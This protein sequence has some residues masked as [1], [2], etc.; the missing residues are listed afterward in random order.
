MVPHIAYKF[1][2]AYSKEDK[3][4]MSI[5]YVNNKAATIYRHGTVSDIESIIMDRQSKIQK[6]QS[7]NNTIMISDPDKF[8]Q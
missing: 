1:S 7:G 2:L 8:L 4:I 5:P 6:Y 3:V